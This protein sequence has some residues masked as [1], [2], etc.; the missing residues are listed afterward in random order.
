MMQAMGM[1][2]G[3]S[4][5]QMTRQP[6]LKTLRFF[7]GTTLL[8]TVFGMQG[9]YAAGG[10]NV[11]D[12]QILDADTCQLESW[13]KF[14]RTGTERWVSPACS[15]NEH[16]EFSWAGSWQRD[17]RGNYMAASQFQGKTVLRELS[18]DVTAIGM[19]AG[20]ERI[21]EGMTD[22]D[23]ARQADW[24]Y[25]AKLLTTT[26]FRDDD[27][28]LHTNLGVS[29]SKENHTTSLTWGVGNETRLFG[30]STFIAEV[31][32]ENK[33]R[34]SYQAGVRHTL[35]PEQLELDLTYG[36][37]FGRDTQEAFVVLGLRFIAPGLFR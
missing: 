33:G 15:P 7:I 22:S 25:Y 20:A 26:S 31:F 19:L 34:P 17:L 37:R 1:A 4:T 9:A 11:D 32:G 28:L 5:A 29:Q 8:Y 35:I 30:K 24:N 12:A 2:V 27:I 16:V 36:N 6:V 13:A 10:M 14:N 21:T 23:S 3:H 18:S